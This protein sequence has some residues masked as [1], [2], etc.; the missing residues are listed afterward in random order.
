M[1]ESEPRTVPVRCAECG[2]RAELRQVEAGSRLYVTEIVPTCK[3][4]LQGMAIAAC[5]RLRE[6]SLA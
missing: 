1:V 4:G 3:H 2:T 6:E 5:P